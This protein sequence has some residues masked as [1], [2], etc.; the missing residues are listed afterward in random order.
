[1]NYNKFAKSKKR[2]DNKELNHFIVFDD[3]LKISMGSILGKWFP[4]VRE[5]AHS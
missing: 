1:M 5:R 3:H 2:W 4:F